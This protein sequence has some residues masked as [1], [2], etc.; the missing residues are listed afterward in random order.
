[1]FLSL[2]LCEGALLEAF[3]L[4]LGGARFG[5]SVRQNKRASQRHVHIEGSIM[6]FEDCSRNA[7]SRRSSIDDNITTCQFSEGRQRIAKKPFE[8]I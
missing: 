2:C 4:L 7:L 5:G 1:M 8:N 6:S 3:S